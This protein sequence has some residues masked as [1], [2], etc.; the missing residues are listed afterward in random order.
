MDRVALIEAAAKKIQNKNFYSDLVGDSEPGKG[1]GEQKGKLSRPES[2]KGS[3]NKSIDGLDLQHPHGTA[4]TTLSNPAAP[5]KLQRPPSRK[6]D[7][8]QSAK[9]GLG[10][11]IHTQGKAFGYEG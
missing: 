9:Q 2:R 11:E 6:K 10:G 1:A 8:S 4:S 5:R 3:R 7:P